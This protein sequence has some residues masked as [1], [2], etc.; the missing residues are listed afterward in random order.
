[1]YTSKIPT[2]TF[3]TMRSTASRKRRI[4]I[5]KPKKAAA[6][7]RALIPDDGREHFGVLLLT[8]ANTV[9][10]WHVIGIGGV[11]RVTSSLREIFGAALRT[12]GCASIL[13]VHNHPSGDVKPSKHDTKLTRDLAKA[14]KLLDIRLHDHVIIGN[15]TEQFYSFDSMGGITR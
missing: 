7:G 10:G 3:L 9:L 15:G 5:S 2:V 11:D 6:M 13:C 8:T 1:M 14:A 4:K 12:P